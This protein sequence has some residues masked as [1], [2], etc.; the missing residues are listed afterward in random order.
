MYG[1]VIH[2]QSIMCMDL[3]TFVFSHS[4]IAAPNSQDIHGLT[5]YE[6]AKSKNLTYCMLVLQSHEKYRERKNKSD[7][8]NEE[9]ILK[10]KSAELSVHSRYLLV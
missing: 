6:Y 2:F 10:D 3:L 8:N 9:N 4:F 1:N 5:P 7:P